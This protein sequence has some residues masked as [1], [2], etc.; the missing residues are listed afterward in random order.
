MFEQ[1]NG[2][3]IV[4]VKGLLKEDFGDTGFILKTTL[5]YLLTIAF[6]SLLGLVR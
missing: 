6:S 2:L 5:P 3:V 4:L 1:L